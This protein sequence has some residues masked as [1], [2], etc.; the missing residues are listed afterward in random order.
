MRQA[1]T[2]ARD[3]HL[4]ALSRRSAASSRQRAERIEMMH[5]FDHANYDTYVCPPKHEQQLAL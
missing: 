5:R 4:P 2:A 3:R 1:G